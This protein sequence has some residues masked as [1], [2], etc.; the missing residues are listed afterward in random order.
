MI[1]L[2]SFSA[3]GAREQEPGACKSADI[4]NGGRLRQRTVA[5]FKVFNTKTLAFVLKTL[6]CKTLG[7]KVVFQKKS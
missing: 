4:I 2:V 3:S 5:D 6:K 1:H 7:R